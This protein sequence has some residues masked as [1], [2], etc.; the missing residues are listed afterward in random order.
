MAGHLVHNTR[1]DPTQDVSSLQVAWFSGRDICACAGVIS[2]WDNLAHDASEPNV[3]C[4][5]WY[6]L[7]ALSALTQ[8]SDIRIFTLWEGEPERSMLMGL[9]PTGEHTK[10]AGLPVRHYQNWLHPNAFLGTPLVRK[11]YEHAFWRSL[12]DEFDMQEGRAMFLHLNG[13]NAQGPLQHALEQICKNDGRNI[14]LVHTAQRAF[15]Q[16]DLSPGAYY[17]SAMRGKKRKELRRQHNRLAELGDLQF[18]RH[19]GRC[20]L[21]AWT[22]EFLALERRGWKGASGSA[23]DCD[24]GT[25][26]LFAAALSGAAGQGKLE[27][28]ELR[29]NGAP[30]AMLINFISA[31]GSFSFKTAFDEDYA[32]YSPGVLLQ[33]EN[34][35]LLER[36]DTQ[37]CDSCAAEDHPMIDS[38]WRERRQIGR[39]SVAIGGST[40]R[41]IFGAMLKAELAKM[42]WRAR[43][44]KNIKITTQGHDI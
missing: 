13:M 11:G 20:G 43:G 32:R 23:L 25:R 16:S 6:L 22:A 33:I 18:A 1:Y 27:L 36:G 7:P 42:Q 30:L 14:A 3:F 12:L 37:W 28:L 8:H 9:M 41:L 21:E 31:P 35:A 38:L 10:Y 26:A 44:D 17:E 24:N 5:H 4:E 19:D 34:L 39:Y 15:L 29:L 2:A 40:R